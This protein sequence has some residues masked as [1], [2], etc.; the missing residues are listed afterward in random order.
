MIKRIVLFLILTS[1]VVGCSPADISPTQSPTA[2]VSPTTTPSLLPSVTPTITPFPSMQTQGPYLL[3]TRHNETL[4]VMDADGSG[5]KQVQLPNDATI[6]QLEAVSPDRK[7]LA[8]FTGSAQEP[9]DLTLNLFNLWDETT[10]SIARL[11]AP[12]YPENLMLTTLNKDLCPAEFPDCQ[13]GAIRSDFESA[14]TKA[15]DWSPDSKTLAFAAQIDGP[16]SDVYLYNIE[17]KSLRRLVDDLE[18]VW[19]IDW[20]PTGNK[21]L[22]ENFQSGNYM[23]R[24]LYIA[25]PI[26]TTVQSPYLIKSAA[27]GGKEGWID[28]NLLLISD[29][30]HSGPAY[31]FRIINTETGSSKIIW[32]HETEI[33]GSSTELQSLII[34]VP[35]E[36]VEYYEIPIEPGTCLVSSD[37]GLIKL[38]NE[39]HE[40]LSEPGLPGSFFARKGRHLYSMNIEGLTTIVKENVDFQ[41]SP[42][43]SP[44]RKWLMV[45]GYDGL[46]LYTENLELVK[47]WEI[48]NAEMIWRPDSVGLFLFM[49]T[50]MSYLPV[51]DG[52]PI[53]IEDCTPDFCSIRNYVW[54]P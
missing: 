14:I 40:P 27:F 3:F 36:T 37:G 25:D 12:G 49:D 50:S 31:D 26:I 46:Q 7:W 2:V 16:S 38:S 17:D 9:Y 51:P 34:A 54:L 21:V 8:Y 4:T 52:E 44:N 19:D 48:R 24:E 35:P 20:S 18:N 43:L 15:M 6:W 42:R 29:R 45:E 22:F 30:G 28:D 47:S 23:Q 53:L 10:H 11:L 33:F 13:A 41:H 39:I 5:R 32:K 1:L